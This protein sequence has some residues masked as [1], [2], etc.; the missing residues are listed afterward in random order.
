MSR[1]EIVSVALVLAFASLVTAHVVLVAGL[2]GRRPRWRSLVALVIAPLAPWWGAREA[3]RWRT[4]AW[5]GSA[6]AY[7]VLRWLA[8]R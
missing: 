3:M 2:L 4:R 5:L 8:S 1:D 7:L 6:I